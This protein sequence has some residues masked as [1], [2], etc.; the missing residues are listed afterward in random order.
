MSPEPAPIERL[1]EHRGPRSRG[2]SENTPPLTAA[3]SANLPM[4]WGRGSGRARKDAA[5]ACMS[6][7]REGGGGEVAAG[8]ADRRGREGDDGIG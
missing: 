3:P 5:V 1:T 7:G 8:E 6:G 4:R 2:G